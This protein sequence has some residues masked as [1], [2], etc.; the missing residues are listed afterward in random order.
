MLAV[1]TTTK[2]VVGAWKNEGYTVTGTNVTGGTLDFVTN[3]V[4]T[5]ENIKLSNGQH[6]AA[7][8]RGARDHAQRVM[9]Q[10]SAGVPPAAACHQSQ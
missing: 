5:G 9:E 4:G 1:E 6:P 3:N 10:P 8:A 2:V 7:T